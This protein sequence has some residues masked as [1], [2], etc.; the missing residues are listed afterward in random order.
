M[1]KVRTL[2]TQAITCGRINLAGEHTDYNL[3]KVMPVGL[4]FTVTTSIVLNQLKV[5]R[6]YSAH[7]EQWITID[8][9]HLQPTMPGHWQ[10]YL[11]GV[12]F[13]LQEKFGHHFPCVDAV[14][15]SDVPIGAG[16][17]SSAALTTSFAKALCT[18]FG[19]HIEEIKLA[20]LCMKAEVL[21]ANVKC[22]LLDHAASLLSKVGQAL[23]LDCRTFNYYHIPCNLNNCNLI[24]LNSHVKHNLSQGGHL[25]QCNEDCYDAVEVVNQHVHQAQCL[26]DV[27]IADLRQIKQL[28]HPAVYMRATYMINEM[29]RFANYEQALMTGDME[30]MGKLFNQTH[31]ELCNYYY[32]SCPEIEALKA[33]AQSC[34]G[35]YGAKLTGG[36]LGGCTINLVS[37]EHTELFIDK[38]CS[39]YYKL[40]EIEC[41]ALLV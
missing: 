13:Q 37:N 40:T 14:V 8:H 41:T 1:T 25:N 28:L 36:G 26:A 7:F 22:G 18:L 34:S 27:S 39:Q 12:L 17:S 33:I 21:F 23:I 31:Y 3:G 35:F 24:V 19:L 10:N 32:I 16:L 6:I 38:C 4:P 5:S 15:D 29:Y 2:G 11:Y 20:K 30:T 9:A